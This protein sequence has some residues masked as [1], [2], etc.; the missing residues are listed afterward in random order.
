M[1]NVPSRNLT[2]AIFLAL[3]SASAQ[4]LVG[5]QARAR[6]DDS[7]VERTFTIR[8]DDTIDAA[9]EVKSQA[10]ELVWESWRQKRPAHCVLIWSSLKDKTEVS[11]YYIRQ[12]A[13]GC[14][15]VFIRF[16]RNYS[17][18]AQPAGN[19]AQMKLVAEKTFRTVERR[20]TVPME[21]RRLIGDD[22]KPKPRT[23]ELWFTDPDEKSERAIEVA[24]L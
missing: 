16:E 18:D 4:T 23:Y 13:G 20:E 24:V 5:R 2:A 14:W 6:A 17:L 15:Q 9:E 12:D 22:E 8:Y 10:R 7:Y 3:I 1:T 21:G 11:H 19:E